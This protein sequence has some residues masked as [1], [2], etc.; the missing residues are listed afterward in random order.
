MSKLKEKQILAIVKDPGKAPQVEPLFTNSL[1]ALQEAVGGRIETLTLSADLVLV[2]NADARPQGLQENIQVFGVGIA[3]P[4]VAVG[5]KG[6][7]FVSLKASNVPYVLNMLG[8]E[9][10]GK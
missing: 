3:G 1:H 5:A 2:C 9:M 10:D 7:R 4:V 6:E 8:G